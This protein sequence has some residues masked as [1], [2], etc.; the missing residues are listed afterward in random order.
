[1]LTDAI[2][3][4]LVEAASRAPSADNMQAWEFGR[5]QD[6]IEVFLAQERLLPTDV[7]GMFGWIGMGAAIENLVLAAARHGLA[8]AVEYGTAERPAVVRLAPGGVDDPLA[9]WLE[10]RVTNRSRYETAPPEAPLLAAITA[11]A[12]VLDAGVHW[13]TGRTALERMAAMD[14]NS[15]YIRLEHQPLHDELFEVLRFSRREVER[16]RYG[17]DFESL[18]VPFVLVRVAQT[19]RYRSVNQ[20][21]SRLGLGRVVAK[22]LASRLRTAGALCLVTARRPGPAGYMEAGRAMERLWLA[23]TA[24]GL[25]V[26]PHGVLPQYLTK[27]E[28]EPETFLPRH[29]T[30]LRGHREPFH[31]LFPAAR[32]ERPAIVLRVGR[33][34]GLPAR[35]SVRLLPEQVVRRS[36]GNG[37]AD[38]AWDHSAEGARRRVV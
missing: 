6:A 12:G 25:A 4:A 38:R 26:Q 22:L 9:D 36:V 30:T 33:P 7:D 16:T 21:A 28:V 27:V 31:A 24:Q 1:M 20:A 19:L 14:A 29:A 10:Q 17:L 35:R 23:A 37:E 18:G 32:H 13:A 3:A 11:A 15:T 34:L 8:A 2:F 5:R